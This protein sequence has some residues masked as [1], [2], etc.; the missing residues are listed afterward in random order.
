MLP[1]EIERK[2][3]VIPRLWN[4]VKDL[5][6][7]KLLKQG[8]LFNWRNHTL[9]VRTTS[10]TDSGDTAYLTYK[11]PG[12]ETTRTELEYKI[13]VRLGNWLLSKCDKV[14]IKERYVYFINKYKWE[15]DHFIYPLMPQ[16]IAEIELPKE[17]AVFIKP[18]WIGKEVTGKPEYY[19][20]NIINR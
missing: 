20:S 19:N 5:C 14:L 7:K 12:S 8:Y 15:V 1:K 16:L 9:R 4:E 17:D 6:S 2:F 3:L 10:G 11:S 13:P 18:K